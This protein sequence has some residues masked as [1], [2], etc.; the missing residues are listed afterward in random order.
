MRVIRCWSLL[1]V[2]ALLNKPNFKVGGGK[3]TMDKYIQTI[4][5]LSF[6]H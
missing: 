5:F 3:W 1:F 4:I 2:L 6:M